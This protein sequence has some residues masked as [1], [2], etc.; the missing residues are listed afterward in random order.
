SRGSA[1]RGDRIRPLSP[2]AAAMRGPCVSD[3]GQPGHPGTP[4][5]C[6]R[7]GRDVDRARPVSGVHVGS[8]G[9]H[10]GWRCSHRPKH[11]RYAMTRRVCMLGLLLL[12]A[13]IVNAAMASTSTV[14]LAIEG[15]T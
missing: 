7:G 10:H 12:V 9:S 5:R 13:L 6:E 15:M 1:R 3:G 8:A 2:R 11:G 4:R 14:V